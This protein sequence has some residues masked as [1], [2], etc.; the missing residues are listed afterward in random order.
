MEILVEIYRTNGVKVRKCL[1]KNWQID[2]PFP[3]TG[4]KA[5]GSRVG[6]YNQPLAQIVWSDAAVFNWQDCIL[7]KT[8][9]QIFR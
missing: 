8:R 5:R 9:L 4:E 1:P 2:G 6:Y 7:Q 3:F